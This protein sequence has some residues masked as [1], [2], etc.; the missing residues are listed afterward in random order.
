MPQRKMLPCKLCG[1]FGYIS[2]AKI[3]DQSCWIGLP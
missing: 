3:H 1:K 2:T